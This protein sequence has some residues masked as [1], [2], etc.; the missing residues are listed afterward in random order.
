MLN[1]AEILREK[2]IGT[3]FFNNR[4]LIFQLDFKVL[5]NT[6][7]SCPTGGL[8][9]WPHAPQ[10]LFCAHGR[11]QRRNSNP[12]L[13]KTSCHSHKSHTHKGACGWTHCSAKEILQLQKKSPLTKI[14]GK[15]STDFPANECLLVRSRRNKPAVGL[16]LMRCSRLA[17]EA[18]YIPQHPLQ[19][20]WD[21]FDIWK[22]WNRSGKI[23]LWCKPIYFIRFRLDLKLVPAGILNDD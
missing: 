23:H 6:A 4:I 16:W 14:N 18:L 9:T 8:S 11:E 5:E 15:A 22:A 17:T 21:F 19:N 3:T 13:Q 1:Y 12:G 20:F 7:N 10:L 2:M